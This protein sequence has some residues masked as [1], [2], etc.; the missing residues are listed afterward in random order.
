MRPRINP[1][2][3]NVAKVVEHLERKRIV[4]SEVI[5]HLMRDKGITYTQAKDLINRKSVEKILF[6]F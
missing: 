4:Y 3:V 6:K 2:K 5:N 1:N